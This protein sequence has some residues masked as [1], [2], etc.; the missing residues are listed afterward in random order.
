MSRKKIENWIVWIV[1]DIL[2][3]GLYVYKDLT[4]TAILYAVFVV[5]ATIG[6]LAWKKAA[7]AAPDAMVLK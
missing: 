5:M 7:P 4:L 3:V 1:V 6:L 2:Y